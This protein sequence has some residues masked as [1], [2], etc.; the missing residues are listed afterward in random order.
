MKRILTSLFLIIPFCVNAQHHLKLWYKQPAR[1]WTE[2][3]P[4]GNGRLGAMVFGGVNNE[5]ISLNE[6]TLWSGG[7]VKTNINPDAVKYL[8]KVREALLVKQD[9]AEAD[10]LEKKMQGLYTESY[11]PLG[12]LIIKQ[13]LADTAYTAYYRDLEISKAIATIRFTSGGVTFTREAFASAPDQVIVI[14]FTADKPGQLNL[15]ISSKSLLHYQVSSGANNELILDGRAPSHTDPSYYTHNDH[16]VE[17]QDT[18]KCAGMRFEM[19]CKAIN[20]GG[21]VQTDDG[22]ITVK[23][24]NSLTLMISAATSFNGF[25]HCPDKDL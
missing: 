19:I 20:D 6:G 18:D 3:L 13:E 21:N 7:P 23:N 1:V 9:Y 11:E 15:K 12:D 24:A 14:H 5:M 16:P 22:T 4:L 8:A 17:Y 2:A 25:D 10:R